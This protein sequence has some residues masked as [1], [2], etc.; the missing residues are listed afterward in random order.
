MNIYTMD[1]SLSSLANINNVY[2]PIY[3]NN[4]PYS[5][6]L[7]LKIGRTI[8]IVNKK[9]NLVVTTIGRVISGKRAREIIKVLNGYSKANNLFYIR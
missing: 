4:I 5:L 3:V 9:N 7:K 6:Q 1:Q 8:V 2:E